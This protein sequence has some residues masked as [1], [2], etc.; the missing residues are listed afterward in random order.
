MIHCSLTDYDHP[1]T[2]N[3]ARS[4]RGGATPSLASDYELKMALDS[5][6]R[7]LDRTVESMGPTDTGPPPS[8]SKA[9][10]YSSYYGDREDSFS[11]EKP[12]TSS[13]L[14]N[15]SYGKYASK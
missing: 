1:Y 3:S 7:S 8:S 5:L 4:P 15:R 14:W 2:H 6:D 13:Y 9:L 10:H 11:L 12:Y